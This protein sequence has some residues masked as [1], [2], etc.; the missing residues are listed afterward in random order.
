MRSDNLD[1]LKTFANK[2]LLFV[3]IGN[4]L[5]SDDGVGIYISQRLS[6]QGKWQ[7]LLVESGIEKFIGKINSLDPDIM[8]LID[9]TD[10]GKEP[11]FFRLLPLTDT[12][13]N[14]FNTHTISLHSLQDFFKMDK[15]LL[16]IQPGDISI[17]ENFTPAVKTTADLII[18][19]INAIGMRR[20]K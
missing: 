11:G 14:T 12:I 20:N 13:D 8:I 9:C 15:Y 6:C 10:F 7:N 17:G 16:G 1:F 5:K 3:G 18:K 2:S 19:K 4:A